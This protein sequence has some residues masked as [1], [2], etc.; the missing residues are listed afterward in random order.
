MNQTTNWKELTLY[1][2]GGDECTLLSD[3]ASFRAAL[4]EHREYGT[5]SGYYFTEGARDSVDDIEDLAPE[6]EW[7][8]F[9]TFHVVPSSD[10]S[11]YYAAGYDGNNFASRQEA[12]AAIP[13]LIETCG[14]PEDGGTWIVVEA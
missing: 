3:R 8:G 13:G 4:R 6:I 10:R 2:I 12:E 11:D 1:G 9:L 7:E 5:M 14:E